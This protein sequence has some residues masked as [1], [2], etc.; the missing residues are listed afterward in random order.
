[1]AALERTREPGLVE[2]VE[3]PPAFPEILDA[4]VHLVKPTLGHYLR[5]PLVLL[6]GEAFNV[7]KQHLGIG[8][9][10]RPIDMLAAIPER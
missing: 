7:L 6:V 1:M 4:E 10:D 9:Q 3:A 5:L 2:R 8:G